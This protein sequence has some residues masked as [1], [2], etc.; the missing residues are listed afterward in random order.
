MKKQTEQERL[1]G[2]ISPMPA[3]RRGTPVRVYMGAGWE[4]GF[5]DHCDR[6]GCTVRLAR[7]QKST[8]VHDA[9]NIQTTSD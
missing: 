4:K 6:Q 5:V 7:R 8:R 1:A 9:R 2:P 3:L